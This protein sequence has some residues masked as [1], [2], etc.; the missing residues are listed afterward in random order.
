MNSFHALYKDSQKAQEDWHN[1]DLYDHKTNLNSKTYM[2]DIQVG[3]QDWY[4]IID[5]YA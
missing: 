1:F 3:C 5:L 2:G 4:L